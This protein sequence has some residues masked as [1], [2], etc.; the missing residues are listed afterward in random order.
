MRG[1]LRASLT[2]N[3]DMIERALPVFAAARQQAQN[4]VTST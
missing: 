3:D 2:A 1:Y 4:L